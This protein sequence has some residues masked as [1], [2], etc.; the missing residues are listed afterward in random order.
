MLHSFLQLLMK[1]FA[2]FLEWD[3]LLP[4]IRFELVRLQSPED[5]YFNWITKI[6]P[7]WFQWR[8]PWIWVCCGLRERSR[9]WQFLPR[10]LPCR[11]LCLRPCSSDLSGSEFLLS[12]LNNSYYL[13]VMNFWIFIIESLEERII[14]RK[15]YKIGERAFL[16][17]SRIFFLKPSKRTPFFLQV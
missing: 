14:K 3:D 11:S 8:V 9:H 4:Y 1:L 12:G 7:P 15:K 6:V 16:F 17:R 10:S 5:Q 2:W 13:V